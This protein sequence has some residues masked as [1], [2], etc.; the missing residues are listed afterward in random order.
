MSTDS[1]SRFVELEREV[2]RGFC[3]VGPADPVFK[4]AT[5]ALQGYSWRY[6][7]HRVVFG[8]LQRVS[9]RDLLT[10]REQLPAAATRMGFPDVDWGRYL[11]APAASADLAELTRELR[12]LVGDAGPGSARSQ[13]AD[14]RRSN[15]RR[16]TDGEWE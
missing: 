7:E 9:A 3:C 1:T 4:T 2:L 13:R 15:E 12:E 14:D 16:M 10:L 8:A 6:Y 5:E 11:D